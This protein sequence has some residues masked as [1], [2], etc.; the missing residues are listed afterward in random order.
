MDGNHIEQRIARENDASCV[1]APLTFKSLEAERSIY[2][3]FGV[4]ISFVKRAELTGFAITIILRI[5]D[6]GKCD[7]LAHY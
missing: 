3:S 7:V 4:R 2:N 6:A 1:H 5:K